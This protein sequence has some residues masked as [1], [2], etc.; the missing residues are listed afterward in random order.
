MRAKKIDANQPRIVEQ[1]RK[2]HVSVRVLSMV[3]EGF[4]DLILGFRKMCFI[5]ELKDGSLPPSKRKLTPE[6]QKFADTWRGQY[7]V[8][9]TLE[10]ILIVIGYKVVTDDGPQF[11]DTVTVDKSEGNY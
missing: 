11:F 1:L 4:P 5:I 2:L 8:C 10:E 6:E 7:A 9:E 3:G